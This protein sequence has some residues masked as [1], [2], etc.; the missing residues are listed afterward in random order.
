M[1]DTK[2][3]ELHPDKE[4]GKITLVVQAESAGYNCGNYAK[5][6]INNV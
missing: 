6:S 1:I 3:N 2:A 4:T 5:I